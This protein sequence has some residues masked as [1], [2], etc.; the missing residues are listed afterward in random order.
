M[1]REPLARQQPATLLL[2]VERFSLANNNLGYVLVNDVLRTVDAFPASTPHRA[3][4]PVWGIA[5]VIDADSSVAT[6]GTR[7]AGFLPMATHTAVRATSTENG[8]LSIDEQRVDMLP[9]Y[10]RLTPLVCG[11]RSIDADVE[12][13]LLPVYPFAAL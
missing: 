7:V 5:E 10:R 4:I 9:V 12:T 3:R 11:S 1:V 2:A 6:R 8:L 13:V